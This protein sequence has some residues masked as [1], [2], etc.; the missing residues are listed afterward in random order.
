MNMKKEDEI[1]YK[2]NKYLELMPMKHIGHIT[3]ESEYISLRDLDTLIDLN[4]SRSIEGFNYKID[5]LNFK[6]EI[7]KIEKKHNKE[8]IELINLEI[9]SFS[10]E[11]M[12]YIYDICSECFQFKQIKLL[13]ASIK[14]NAIHHIIN[15]LNYQHSS[16]GALDISNCP[17]T[18]IPNELINVSML[19]KIQNFDLSFNYQLTAE[20]L[21]N[22]F[23]KNCWLDLKSLR[24]SNIKNI[25]ESS[26]GLANY[27]MS[28]KI[29]HLD[30]GKNFFS[31]KNLESIL[32]SIFPD[33]LS[34]L[35]LEDIEGVDFN[36]LS[37]HISKFLKLKNLNLSQNNLS[38]NEVV[39]L[40]S[41]LNHKDE[42][43]VMDLSLNEYNNK[44][45]VNLLSEMEF[46]KLTSLNLH[47]SDLIGTE[48]K[49]LINS[50]IK[51]T[52]LDLSVNSLNV[53]DL[54]D[55]LNSESSSELKYLNICYPEFIAH[56]NLDIKA[57]KKSK[58]RAID[59]SG[60]NLN[61]SELFNVLMSL[62]STMSHAIMSYNDIDYESLFN[63]IN[64]S[65]QSY[66]TLELSKNNIKDIQILEI[67][68]LALR[69][70]IHLN[71]L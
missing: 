64:D 56:K 32:S 50:N 19:T 71:I 4:S 47:N 52:N 23:T 33:T 60:W 42:F 34:V 43:L 18:D 58:L 12:K 54:N 53:E 67:C 44:D 25:N 41:D 2:K 24:L 11:G 6:N 30:I 9:S 15:K 7:H 65:N 61:K 46:V 20:S 10:C 38:I 16:L 35:S 49:S 36:L 70:N 1:E 22:F 69:K 8:K 17:L 31:H 5:D 63:F 14:G 55:F 3:N 39:K 29:T 66:L 40:L 27:L 68:E 28:R 21:M 48:I 13:H 45:I 62:P 57:L 37:S 59:M 26:D 51:L